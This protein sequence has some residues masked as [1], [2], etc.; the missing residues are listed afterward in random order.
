MRKIFFKF[1]VFLRKSELYN[2]TNLRIMGVAH[3]LTLQIPNPEYR[4]NKQTNKTRSDWFKLETK[5]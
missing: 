5:C 3:H 4:N 1:C 2:L